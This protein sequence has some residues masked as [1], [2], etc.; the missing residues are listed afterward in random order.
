MQE[1]KNSLENFIKQEIEDRKEKPVDFT[2]KVEPMPFLSVFGPK[3]TAGEIFDPADDITDQRAPLNDPEALY[4][5]FVISDDIMDELDDETLDDFEN[6]I[7]PYEDRTEFGVDVAAAAHLD[8]QKSID[9]LKNT[10][11]KEK[12]DEKLDAVKSDEDE[13][14]EA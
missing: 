14:S 12:N 5:Q 3:I 8:L 7:Y 9:R 10:K 6:D 1:K 11:K 2:K 13:P 4:E